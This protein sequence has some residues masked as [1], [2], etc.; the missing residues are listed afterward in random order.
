MT[1]IEMPELRTERLIL[2]GFRPDDLEA[3]ASMLAKPEVMR[4]LGTGETRTVSETWT[5]MASA[6][7]QWGMRGYGFLVLEEAET[8][9]FVG[10]AGILHPYDWPGPELAYALDQPFSGR[11]YATEACLEL[12]R[13]A[14]EDL[15]LP[16]FVSFILPENEASK[17]VVRRLG[18]TR[19][20]D[21]MLFGTVVVECWH[22]TR[23]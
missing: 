15:G 17:R 18:A 12:R 16:S 2:R 14:F 20:A 21:A 22:H 8:G 4:Y 13:W 11:G 23:P 19:G 10:R 6:I 3:Y 5:A 1:T 9:T 7:G